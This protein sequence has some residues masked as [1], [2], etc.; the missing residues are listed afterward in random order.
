ML[1]GL[2]G[3]DLFRVLVHLLGMSRFFRLDCSTRRGVQD[4][5]GYR[6]LI[7]RRAPQLPSPREPFAGPPSRFSAENPVSTGAEEV[8]LCGRIEPLRRSP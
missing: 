8:K 2:N 4:G 6:P 3:G 5:T 1:L 7:G